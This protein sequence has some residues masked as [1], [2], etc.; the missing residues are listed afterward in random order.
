MLKLVLNTYRRLKLNYKIHNSQYFS[1]DWYE[2]QY[3]SQ[4]D[5]FSGSA[6][7][8]YLAIGWKLGND[9]SKKFS[10]SGYLAKYKD[11]RDSGECPLVHF[12]NHGQQ[13]QRTPVTIKSFDFNSVPKE[14]K[15][16]YSQLEYV[17]SENDTY[18]PTQ[19]VGIVCHVYYLDL[20][21]PILSYITK[22]ETPYKLYITTPK[23]N[24]SEVERL[25]ISS[26][27]N[28]EI[29]VVENAGYDLL[30]F[31]KVLPKLKE[32]GIKYVCKLHTKKGA[33]N[34]ESHYDGIDSVWNDL[35]IKPI[36]SSNKI[37]S[38][39]LYAFETDEKLGFVSS[40]SV[41]KSSSH[42]AYGNAVAVSNIINELNSNQDPSI[43]WGFSAG[44]MFWCDFEILR[45]LLKL[46]TSE[47]PEVSATGDY[48]SYWHALERVLGILP[49]IANKTVALS[50]IT[51]T[52]NSKFTLGKLNDQYTSFINRYGIGLTLSTEYTL[53]KDELLLRKNFPAEDNYSPLENS[54]ERTDNRIDPVLY[55]LRYGTFLAQELTEDFNSATYWHFY[56]DVLDARINPLVHFITHGNAQGRI[57][58]PAISN[59]RENIR[60]VQMEENFSELFYLEE[61]TDVLTSGMSPVEHFC[62]FG[63]KELRNPSLNFD[64]WHEWQALLDIKRAIINPLVYKLL[65]GKEQEKS[66]SNVLLSEGLSYTKKESVRRICLFAGYDV[67]GVIDQSVLNY[68]E[69]LS[70]YAD[71]YYLADSNMAD[72]E[73]DKLSNITIKAWAFRHGA[74]D[75]GSY[76]KLAINLVG[77]ECISQYDELIL[78]NDSCYLIDSLKPV[79]DKMYASKCDWWGMQATKG[80]AKTKD[81]PSNLF[82]KNIPINEVKKSY[83]QEYE[84]E[85]FYD[86][87]IGSYFVTFRKNVIAGGELK[88]LLESVRPEK[89]KLNIIRKYE[90]GLTRLLINS[91]YNFDTFIDDLFTFHPIYT[92]N[93]F[94]LIEQGFPFFKRFFLTEN[95]YHVP[96]LYTWEDKLQKMKPNLDLE[97]IKDNLYRV[98]NNEKLYKNFNITLDDSGNFQYP[99]MLTNEE[100]IQRDESEE[101]DNNL[102]I[103]PACAY[104]NNITGNERAVFELVKNDPSIK[105][106]ILTRKNLLNLTGENVTTCLLN[107]IEG[108]EYLIHSKIIFVKHSPRV[109]IPFSINSQLHHFIN[110]WHGIPL[111]RIGCASLDLQ[112]MLPRLQKENRRNTAVICS[113]DVDRMAMAAAFYPLTYDNMWLT[114]LPRIDTI[115]KQEELLA[116]DLASEL[117]LVKNL[118]KGRKLLFFCPTFKNGQKES[119]YRFSYFEKQELNRWLK[120]NNYVLGIREHMADSASSYMDNLSDLEVLDLGSKRIK[121]IELIYRVADSLIT[122]YSSCFIDFMVTS[123]PI[124]SFAYDHDTYINSER[125]VFY[126]LEFAFPGSVCLNFEQLFTALNQLSSGT[127][128]SNHESTYALK[129]RLFFNNIDTDNSLRLVERVKA[130]YSIK[131]A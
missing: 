130:L 109:N 99:K 120:E 50:F 7:T 24:V 117:T 6:L 87:L 65:L 49:L 11:V 47:A 3:S 86:F 58:F 102:W 121:N 33:A 31:L 108:Q 101:K 60:I 15:T 112:H 89:S 90:V 122:D 20:F 63:W 45:P 8:H 73:L 68:I 66:A 93:H 76:S 48:A 129:Q 59:V 91:G 44:S 126:D 82:E 67:D 70:K 2:E 10:T 98:A 113:S 71:V 79:F 36:I 40:A 72:S 39:I 81:K 57:S 32:D 105:K 106:V 103:F 111:K 41:F 4:L 75:F 123:K 85:C 124:I 35:L 53:K 62:K 27:E 92:E 114:G 25:V 21:P 12:L 23:E 104:D 127:Y 78:A 28:V 77:W 1:K 128:M 119:Y 26:A 64:I 110:L 54:A 94:K 13:E 83:L 52:L 42:L 56:K 38:D 88:A 5:L 97:P 115:L 43:E 100:F 131:E 37:V 96:D 74:Y 19:K 95:H 22:L 30:P 116:D 118:L 80:L 29:I 84:N 18:T 34:L 125:G 46:N 9:P 51:D 61:N 69:E 14:T 17:N 107:S 16:E 55:Y